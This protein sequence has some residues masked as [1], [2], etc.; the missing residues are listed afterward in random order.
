MPFFMQFLKDMKCESIDILIGEKVSQFLKQHS[1]P[2]DD[3]SG[4]SD[5]DLITFKEIFQ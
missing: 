4:L 2:L 1:C 3:L 5:E